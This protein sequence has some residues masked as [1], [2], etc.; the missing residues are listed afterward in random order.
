MIA[1]QQP[2]VVA[3][4][5]VSRGWLIDGS[6]DLVDWLARRLGMEVVFAGTADPIWG[7][8][9]LSRVGFIDHGSA[10][11]P[12]AETLLPR[13]YVWAHVDLGLEQPLLVVATH[14]HHIA[15]EPGP[16]LAQIPVLLD[17]WGGADHSVL[18]GDLNSEPTWPEM[19]LILNAGMV[20]AWVGGRPGTGPDVAGGRSVPAHRLDLAQPRPA[21]RRRRDGG[22]QRLG[23]PRRRGRP[24]RALTADP[25]DA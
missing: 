7:N 17:F 2:D 16:R 1:A 24:R 23:P 3:L 8:A 22:R 12:L 14:L 4:Q 11:L 19:E 18:M 5:E 6:V 25:D 13:G 15:E 21:G 20:D 9:I 10:P